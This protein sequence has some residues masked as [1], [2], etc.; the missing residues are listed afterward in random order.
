M[1][2]KTRY[3]PLLALLMLVFWG[4]QVPTKT[5]IDGQQVWIDQ[6]LPV[7]GKFTITKDDNPTTGYQWQFDYDKEYL[8]LV[9]KEYRSHQQPGDKRVGVGGTSKFTFRALKPGLTKII[10]KY[11]RPWEK[12]PFPEET[13]HV[14]IY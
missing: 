14:L 4:C 10:M 5:T 8:E 6:R 7:N 11:H 12:R 1:L 2:T 3:W 13:I 9:G